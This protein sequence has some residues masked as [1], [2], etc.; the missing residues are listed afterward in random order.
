[1]TGLPNDATLEKLVRAICKND[2]DFVRS[3]LTVN[4]EEAVHIDS[5]PFYPLRWPAYDWLAFPRVITIQYL[6]KQGCDASAISGDKRSLLYVAVKGCVETEAFEILQM[7]PDAGADPT[8]RSAR[9][10]LIE[11]P[12]S[13]DYVKIKAILRSDTNY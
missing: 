4:S 6:L 5:L 8:E 12:N 3:M 9:L 1:M 10:A 11:L 2:F 13:G 7:L